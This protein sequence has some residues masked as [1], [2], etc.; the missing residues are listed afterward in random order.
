MVYRERAPVLYFD[1]ISHVHATLHDGKSVY[2][3]VCRLLVQNIFLKIICV[4]FEIIQVIGR[5]VP[6]IV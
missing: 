6:S 4:D 1:P 5:S 3:T 2:L